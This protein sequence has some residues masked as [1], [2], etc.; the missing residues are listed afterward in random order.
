MAGPDEVSRT[1]SMQPSISG[2]VRTNSPA[3]STRS[4][5]ALTRSPHPIGA[6]P[7]A[8]G[9]GRVRA[10]VRNAGLGVTSTAVN[11]DTGSAIGADPCGMRAMR[12][13][14]TGFHSR[15]TYAPWA[16]VLSIAER[17]RGSS[18]EYTV[19]STQSGVHTL[20]DPGSVGIGSRR[21][22][23][24]FCRRWVATNTHPMTDA[25]Y[26]VL[27]TRYSHLLSERG[28]VLSPDG[29]H[30]R[31]R[32]GIVLGPL[33]R[34]LGCIRQRGGDVHLVE[35]RGGGQLPGELPP[36]VVRSDPGAVGRPR[37]PYPHPVDP[38]RLL[39]L[40]VGHVADPGPPAGQL[41]V[42]PPGGVERAIPASGIAHV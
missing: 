40:E 9:P 31:L 35:H 16:A 1:K 6:R 21:C 15:S 17:D 5:A 36:R 7:W 18:P 27:W 14:R 29:G 12:F 10:G 34:I 2:R 20:C 22:R 37:P 28:R 13:G 33:G 39:L 23:Q 26:W 38:G 8:A 11:R 32:D 42:L 30:E 24:P 41:Q 19:R 25:E 3:A 4:A